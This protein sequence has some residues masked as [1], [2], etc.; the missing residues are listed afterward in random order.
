MAHHLSTADY[1]KA[2]EVAARGVARIEYTQEDEKLNLF[3]ALISCELNFGSEA[4]L[5][6]AIVNA[7]Q[8]CNGKKVYLRTAELLVADAGAKAGKEAANAKDRVDQHMAA[9]CKK[10]KS[11]NQVWIAH[12]K[13]LVQDGRHK[14]ANALVKRS[15]LSLP[16][17]KQL[18]VMSKFAQFEYEFGSAERGRTVMEGL[19]EQN[20][21]KLDLWYVFVDREVKVDLD[22]V[23]IL[24]K[25]MIGAKFND[26]AMKSTF[27]K[28][29]KIEQKWGTKATCA[30]VTKSA[31]E[32][33]YTRDAWEEVFAVEFVS[34]GFVEDADARAWMERHAERWNHD[35]PNWFVKWRD[36]NEA[37]ANLAN[38]WQS[39]AAPLRQPVAKECF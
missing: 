37:E 12:I 10:F 27:K 11:K 36:G 34:A 15:M 17:H 25:K 30:A 24:F 33:E 13:W 32:Y 8:N 3:M 5:Q 19:V 29:L 4:S 7:A 1:K 39:T 21:K 35:R 16:Q 31:K 38:R 14:E 22:F 2:K 18:E 23:R 20:P 28:W 6:E 26:R 9:A